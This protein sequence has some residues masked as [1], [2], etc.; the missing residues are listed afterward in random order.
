MIRDGTDLIGHRGISLQ[1]SSLWYAL[2]C[3]AQS[4]AVSDDPN[5]GA[6]TTPCKKSIYSIH[7]A[8]NQALDLVE[9][10]KFIFSLQ[11]V[12]ESTPIFF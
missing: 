7:T 11:I 9:L 8:R 2:Q 4:M 5:N 10:L 12:Q 6:S 1:V 3:F